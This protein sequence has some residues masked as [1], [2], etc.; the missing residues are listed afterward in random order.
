MFKLSKLTDYAVVVLSDMARRSDAVQTVPQLAERTGLPA[1]TVAKL[2]KLLT[3]AGLAVSHRGAQGG[4]VLARGAT[5]ISV[6]EIIAAVEGPIALT[7]CVEGS[8]QACNAE[9]MCPMRGNWERVNG[10]VRDALE[11]VSLAEMMSFPDFMAPRA[12]RPDGEGR[13]G[14]ARNS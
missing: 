8:D 4:Y 7:A 3:P 9:R 14:A 11:R 2:M 6:A 10:A 12:G 1:P 5:D 13:I